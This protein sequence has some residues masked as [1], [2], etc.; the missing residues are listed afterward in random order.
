M[1]AQVPYY[2][3][4]LNPE[5]WKTINGAKVHL[6][7][8]GNYDA[9]ADGKFNGSHHY[10]PDY[11]AM[12]AHMNNLANAFRQV[13]AQKQAQG[14]GQGTRLQKC[15]SKSDTRWGEWWYMLHLSIYFGHKNENNGHEM[16]NLGHLR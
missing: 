10:G 2:E 5:H 14:N 8:N 7:K 6:D 1:L 3:K 16:I 12:N 9:D 4:D 15:R 13:V 11:K